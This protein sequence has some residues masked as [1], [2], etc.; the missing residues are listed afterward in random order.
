MYGKVH[1]IV[2]GGVTNIGLESTVL[3]VSGDKPVILR[4]GGVTKEDL[5]KVVGPVLVS[6]GEKVGPEVVSPGSRYKHYAPRAEVVVA[7]GP[8]TGQ[9]FKITPHALRAVFKGDKVAVLSSDENAGFYNDLASITQ[10]HLHVFNLGSRRHIQTVAARVYSGLRFADQVGARLVLAET[11]CRS[12]LGLAVNNRLEEAGNRKTTGSKPFNVL[13]V[14]SGNTCRSPMAKG[15]LESIWVERGKPFP[16]EVTSAGTAAVQGI[17]ASPQAIAVMKK[18]GIDIGGHESKPVTG[19]LLENSD[20]VITMTQGH[21]EHLA[22]KFPC[23]T[24]KIKSLS[25]LASGTIRGDVMDP[26]CLDEKAYEDTANLLE[27][28]FREFT[29]KL[30]G[31]S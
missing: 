1:Y 31:K 23:Y 14:C 27:K 11:F 6:N 5:E 24:S 3:D 22:S 7:T 29:S 21:K 28:A 10:G 9:I 25:H 30:T 18:K 17:P 19:G 20:L 15:L 13:I 12:G 4:P 8:G 2:D 16:L 26:Y